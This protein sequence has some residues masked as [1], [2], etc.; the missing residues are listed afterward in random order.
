MRAALLPTSKRINAFLVASNQASVCAHAVVFG[1]ASPPN[2]GQPRLYRRLRP[3]GRRACAPV[4]AA[5]SVPP[6]LALRRRRS[7]VAGSLTT[8]LRCRA[9]GF[10]RFAPRFRALALPL[11]CVRLL[12]SA[13]SV[14]LCVRRGAFS[15][16]S[17]TFTPALSVAPRGA[18]LFCRL[19]SARPPTR[20]GIFAA[21]RKAL[22]VFAPARALTR[23]RFYA[24]G[25]VAPPSAPYSGERL[26]GDKGWVLCFSRS[27]CAIFPLVLGSALLNRGGGFY[28]AENLFLTF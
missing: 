15:T 9:R 27:A 1:V 23:L 13:P 22:G 3:A 25:S 28:L 6:A 7:A 19:S 4:L 2:I 16:R 24:V 10:R 21:S 5:A 26:S 11:V 12:L 20:G 14:R 8:A 18:P 17:S